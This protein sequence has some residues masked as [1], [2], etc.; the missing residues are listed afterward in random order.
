MSASHSNSRSSSA[1]RDAAKEGKT[2]SSYTYSK[3]LL[4]STKLLWDDITT[5]TYKDDFIKANK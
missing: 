1:S 5:E 2:S 3:A 4:Y